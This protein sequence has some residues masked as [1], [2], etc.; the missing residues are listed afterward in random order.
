MA[1]TDWSNVPG[2]DWATLTKGTERK[3]YVPG[4]GWQFPATINKKRAEKGLPPI[5]DPGQPQKPRSTPTPTPSPTPAPSPTP[6]PTPAPSPT[7]SPTPAPTP[8]PSP[9]RPTSS[10]SASTAEKIKGGLETY[11][12]QVSAGDVKGA[13]ATGKATWALAN[14]KLAAAAAE[15]ERTRGTSATT[16]P[17]MKDMKSKLTAPMKESYDAFDI[18]L[19]YLL[20]TGHADTIDEA[21]YIMMKMDSE[22]IQNI[23]ENVSDEPKLKPGSGLGGGKPTYEKGKEPIKTGAKLPPV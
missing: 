15:R 22:F 16:N 2:K 21:L 12:K 5:K 23:V 19:E 20:S 6:S 8:T 3:I 18:V 13:E 14:P 9:S 17:L 7:P 4:V 10:A 1:S 11:K